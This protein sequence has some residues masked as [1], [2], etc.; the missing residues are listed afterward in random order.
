MRPDEKP[1]ADNPAGGNFFKS[2]VRSGAKGCVGCLTFVVLAII[3]IAVVA[4]VASH[5]KKK[6]NLARV[7]GK[8]AG[9]FYRPG[10]FGC[11][12]SRLLAKIRTPG[13]VWC[14]WSGS[15]VVVHV[16][17]RNT[18]SQRTK[19][20]W[21]PAYVIADGGLHGNGLTSIQTTTLNAGEIRT[22]D[23]TQNPKGVSAG[24]PIAL[25]EPSFSLVTSG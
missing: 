6:I 5:G 22:L 16:V 18:A 24:T 11:G 4:A 8:T 9:V 2:G 25:C 19:V 20:E 3:V 7:T 12:D 1:A 10:C 15:T 17:M 14:G 21:H 13:P 23:A